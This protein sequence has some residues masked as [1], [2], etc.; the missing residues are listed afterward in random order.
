MFGGLQWGHLSRALKDKEVSTGQRIAE[1][2]ARAGTRSRSGPVTL[3]GVGTGTFSLV[4]ADTKRVG[5]QRLP[6]GA[7]ALSVDLG[8]KGRKDGITGSLECQVKGLGL[9]L[10]RGR[11]D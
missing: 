11:V 8:W 6:R 9:Y 2:I 5:A 3:P 10:G 1:G 4:T 7:G